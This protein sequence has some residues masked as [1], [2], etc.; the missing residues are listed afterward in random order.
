MFHVFKS[1]RKRRRKRPRREIRAKGEDRE[2]RVVIICKI[3]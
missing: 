3:A 1:L 2:R